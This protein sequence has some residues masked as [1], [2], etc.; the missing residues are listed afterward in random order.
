MDLG[1][2][3][4]L[5]V[6]GVYA[7]LGPFVFFLIYIFFDRLAERTPHSVRP[8]SDKSRDPAIWSYSDVDVYLD[9]KDSQM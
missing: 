6:L 3:L 5:Q 8:K 1:I 9:K 4:A 2:Q 7:L